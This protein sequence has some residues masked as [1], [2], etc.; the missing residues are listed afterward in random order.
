MAYHPS[1]PKTKKKRREYSFN[2]ILAFDE[3]SQACD[4]TDYELQRVVH[5]VYKNCFAVQANIFCVLVPVKRSL[6]PDT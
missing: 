3:R 4:Q 6:F 5:N 1:Q 2:I